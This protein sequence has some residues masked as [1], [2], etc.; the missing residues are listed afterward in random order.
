M[1][2]IRTGHTEP[3]SVPHDHSLLPYKLYKLY[4]I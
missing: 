3:L 4:T 2:L 1:G